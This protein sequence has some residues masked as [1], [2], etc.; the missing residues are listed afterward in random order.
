MFKLVVPPVK[1]FTRNV[2]CVPKHQAPDPKD[3]QILQ[4]YLHKHA[5]ILFLTGAGISTES[6]KNSKLNFNN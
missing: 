4:E 1:S 2:V 5:K 3:F 6:G